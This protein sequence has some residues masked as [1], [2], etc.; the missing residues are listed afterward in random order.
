MGSGVA[1]QCSRNRCLAGW[2]SRSPIV[3]AE[4]QQVE[5]TR[6]KDLVTGPIRGFCALQALPGTGA[7]IRT[8]DLADRAGRQSQLEIRATSGYCSRR[9]R[10]DWCATI[11]Y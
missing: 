8:A 6:T 4:A 7:S 2:Q 1:R 10:F 5:P 3:A 11:R 9:R